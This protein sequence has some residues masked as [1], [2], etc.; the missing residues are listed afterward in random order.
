MKSPDGNRRLVVL[1]HGAKGSG[2]DMAPLANHLHNALPDALFAAPNAPYGYENGPG[3]QWFSLK[4]I[5]AENRPGRVV[6]ARPDFDAV[7]R[8][9]LK[10]HC[11]CGA[12]DRLILA[13]FSQGAIMALDAVV[14]GRWPVAAAISFC[15]WL[16]TPPPL[17]ANLSTRL[18][19]FHGADDQVIAAQETIKAADALKESDF[20][21][22]SHILENVGHAMPKGA[23][24]LASAFLARL[25]VVA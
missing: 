8:S 7:L 9:E 23:L 25:M 18:L 16:A 11:L 19:L 24:D 1:L 13:S 21:V 15:G 12:F 10:K 4:G 2:A 17:A 6:G 3:Y 14:S 5:T 20:N 22:E